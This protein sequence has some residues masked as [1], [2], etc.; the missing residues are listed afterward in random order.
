MTGCNAGQYLENWTLSGVPTSRST[1]YTSLHRSLASNA[2]GDNRQCTSRQAESDSF[3]YTQF[4]PTPQGSAEPTAG[5]ASLVLTSSRR[6][7]VF[8]V[9]TFRKATFTLVALPRSP[10]Y[11]ESIHV[12][13]ALKNSAEGMSSFPL[14]PPTAPVFSS[15]VKPRPCVCPAAPPPANS[16]A[17]SAWARSS[18]LRGC[19]CFWVERSSDRACG[20]ES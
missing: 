2:S 9:L 18:L 11:L 19:R 17:F 10:G 6:G 14:L 8:L 12:S 1:V 5:H 16:K 3:I 4:L 7:G 20:E 15:Y 13:K